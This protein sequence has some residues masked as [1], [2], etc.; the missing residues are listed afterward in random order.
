M[1]RRRPLLVLC[2]AAVPAALVGSPAGAHLI[3]SSGPP[4][5]L[6]SNP[7]YYANC[8]QCHGGFVNSGDG[9]LVIEGVP[10]EYTPGVKY[11]ITV[12]LGDP[13]QRRWG[14]EVAVFGAAGKDIG[15]TTITDSAHTQK[16]ALGHRSWI[17]HTGAGT[18]PG[19][20]NGPVSWTFDWTAPPAGSGTAFFHA[21]GNAANN[22][23]STNGDFIYNTATASAE[24]GAAHSDATLVLQPDTLFFARG[25]NVTIRARVR[26]HS[27][28]AQTWFVVSRVRMPSGRFFPAA[29]WLL[30]PQGVSLAPQGWAEASLTHAVPG[31]APLLSAYYQGQVLDGSG[32]SLDVAKF[33][34]VV[35][36]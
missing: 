36:P 7:P 17:K 24:A 4:D 10:A 20:L 25:R 31:T 28:A 2:L 27:S 11:P 1:Q 3:Y 12:T 14:F 9:G 33:R 30:P 22:N 21:S 5:D 32:N 8:T 18:F 19:T 13:G 26:N 15:V 29:G 6:A 16:S 23:F 34:F 35:T